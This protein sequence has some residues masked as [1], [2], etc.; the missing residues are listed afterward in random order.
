MPHPPGS[1]LF[2]LVGR[3]FSLL[4]FPSDIAFRVTLF[5]AIVSALAIFFL[6]LTIVMIIRH[7]RGPE[8]SVSDQ[9]I[10]YGSGIIGSLALCFSYS[11]WFNAV[12]SEVYAVSQ[13]FTHIIVWLTLLWSER[14]DEPG[15]ERILILIAYIMGLA[16]GIHLLMILTIPALALII[17]FRKR[18]FS[19]GSFFWMCVAAGAA[20]IAVYPGIVKWLPGSAAKVGY[21]LPLL[22]IGCVVIAFVWAARA[23]AH[24]TATVL[25]SLLLIVV[26]YSTY[27]MIYIRSNMDTPIDEN[28]PETPAAFLSYLNR[29][30][31]GEHSVVDRAW[32]SDPKYSSEWDFFWRYQINKM[33]NRYLLWQFV[34]REGAPDQEF[35]DAGVQNSYIFALPFLLG[36]LGIGYLFYRDKRMG[37][38]VLVLFFMTGYA[39]ILY[40]NQ[41][42]PQPRERDYSYVGSFYAFAIWIGLGATA[43]LDGVASLFRRQRVRRGALLATG[44]LL[45]ILAPVIMLARNFPMQDRTG[46]YVAWD[47]SYNMLMSCEPYGILFTN[48]DNDTFPLWYLQEVEGVRKDV[49]VA[50]LSL[51]N[52]GWYIKQLRDREPRVPISFT[53]AYIDRYIDRRDAQALLSRYWPKERQRIELDT[54]EGKM[55]WNMPATQYVPYRSESRDRNFLRVQDVMVLDIIRT[56][57]DPRRTRNPRPIYF[58]VTVATSNLCGLRDYLTMEGL[59]FRLSPAGGKVIDA[60]RMLLNVLEV[61]ADHYRGLNDPAVHFDDNIQKLL[62]NYRSG[63]LQLAYHYMNQPED[64][65]RTTLT[66]SPGEV[67]AEDFDKLS[68]HD[69]ALFLLDHMASLMPEDVNPISNPELTV[70]LGK[71]YYDLGQ[72]EG[73]RERLDRVMLAG[74]L[75]SSTAARY[76]A[77]YHQVFQDSAKVHQIVD[78]ILLSGDPK[79]ISDAGQILFSV[80]AYAEAA[81]LFEKVLEYDPEDGQGVGGLAQCYERTRRYEDAIALIRR[82]LAKHPEDGGAAAR[83][84]QFERL[85]AA[86]SSD[87]EAQ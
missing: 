42:D 23:K 78:Q 59:A 82:W 45:F 47:Y 24:V 25:A 15:S 41:D 31:Y 33:Y 14:A 18:E 77:I 81:R 74:N 53:D 32:N 17:Y 80:R 50:N 57:Y 54:P 61:Y 28:D 22:V 85:L 8:R 34:G 48:G 16:T 1:P 71:M 3:F 37:L 51:L 58:A 79:Q 39:V 55:V 10:V 86:T 7:W 65:Q 66:Y 40:V 62:Q 83:L 5:P 27:T 4:P 44:V 19:W 60:D 13:F 38:I 56:N 63:F 87:S 30:Q 69:K 43:L 72:P 73:L 67:K 36:L 29:E 20:F 35:Q 2:L 52:T 76:A 12:E 11:M 46:N 75:S 21:W 26:G 70:Q 68:N 6:Y 49:R 64:T 9:I 84:E